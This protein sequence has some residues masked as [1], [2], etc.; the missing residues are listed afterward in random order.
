MH[1]QPLDRSVRGCGV[2]ALEEV[3]GALSSAEH[4]QIFA[5]RMAMQ[6]WSVHGCHAVVLHVG[7]PSRVSHVHRVL[8][9]L[10][11]LATERFSREMH[12][13]RQFC[14]SSCA[15]RPAEKNA[16][17]PCTVCVAAKSI[18]TLRTGV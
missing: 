17:D 6:S 10:A 1:G 2:V 9:A 4:T 16:V 14:G 8:R 18:V 13:P 12:L 7:F 11:W 5:A 3:S 15:V